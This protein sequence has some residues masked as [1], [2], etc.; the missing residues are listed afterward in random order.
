MVD[1]WTHLSVLEKI[2]SAVALFS[3]LILLMQ[4]IAAMFLG[5]MDLDDFDGDLTV[6]TELPVLSVK[7]LTAFFTFFGWTGYLLLRDGV[8][9]LAAVAWAVFAGAVALYFTAWLLKK[10]ARLEHQMQIDLSTTLYQEGEVYL[11]IPGALRGVG[12]VHILVQGTL[13]EVDAKT[14]GLQIPTGEK[15]AVEEV[16]DTTLLVARLPD[17]D[18]V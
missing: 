12:K 3:N 5:D 16:K 17:T 15:I 11:T 10:M 9:V 2:F 6:D 8:W 4:V 13:R 18:S 7:A 1:F 14:R